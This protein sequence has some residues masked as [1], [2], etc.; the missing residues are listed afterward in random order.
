[1]TSGEIAERLR[2]NPRNP[3]HF[4]RQACGR[5]GLRNFVAALPERR[6]V[7]LYRTTVTAVP[8]QILPGIVAGEK[9]PVQLVE[10]GLAASQL[11]SQLFLPAIQKEN[12]AT[13]FLAE[14][15]VI[16]LN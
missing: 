15:R 5:I 7:C 1:M 10:I 4:S 11:K 14:K 2:E 9:C 3:G 13:H 16:K 12:R 8:L 6:G